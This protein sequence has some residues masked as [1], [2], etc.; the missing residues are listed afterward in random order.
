MK[1]KG[2]VEITTQFKN[3]ET[4]E[5]TYGNPKLRDM[6]F[7]SEVGYLY[8]YRDSYVKKFADRPLPQELSWAEKGKLAELQSYIIGDSQV[9]GKRKNGK[10]VSL[11]ID[12]ISEIFKCKERQTLNTLNRAKQYRVVKE[13]TIENIMWY[14]YS[15]IYGFRGK[16]ISLRT[17]MDWQEELSTELP[18]WVRGEFTKQAKLL[19]WGVL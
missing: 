3:M 19:N 17:F 12:D 7:S 4:G 2:K 15:P 9:L 16:R 6:E 13:I 10:I 18:D 5:I 1:N 14:S 8:R 11:S